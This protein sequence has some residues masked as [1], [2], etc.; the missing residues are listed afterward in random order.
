MKAIILLP[1][2]KQQ[3]HFDIRNTNIKKMDKCT[4]SQVIPIVTI[5]RPHHAA[6]S[7][8]KLPLLLKILRL[9]KLVKLVSGAASSLQ[10]FR[11]LEFRVLGF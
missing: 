11:V 10:G 2:L 7:L 1:T 6:T 4:L 9:N 8:D 5:V 3:S